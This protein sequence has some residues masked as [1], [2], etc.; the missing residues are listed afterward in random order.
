MF[1]NNKVKIIDLDDPLTKV[2]IIPNLL[3]SLINTSRLNETIQTLF[4]EEQLTYHNKQL[5]K[6]LGRKKVKFSTKEDWLTNYLANKEQIQDYLL[7]DEFTKIK[8]IKSLMRDKQYRIILI[9]DELMHT[10]KYLINKLLFLRQ[11][12]IF[13]Y[14]IIH[15]QDIESYFSNFPTKEKILIKENKSSLLTN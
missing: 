13:I 4:Q 10:D 1:S 2:E 12:N 15:A 8:T 9:I 5:L 6:L 14:D 7:I 11:N 3:A